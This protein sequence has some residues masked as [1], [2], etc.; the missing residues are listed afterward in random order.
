MNILVKC[1]NSSNNKTFFKL[2]SD[3]DREKA[4]V[5]NFIYTCMRKTGD[6]DEDNLLV[7]LIYPEHTELYLEYTLD[8]SR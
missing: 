8:Y 6:F 4:S 3:R 5:D 1:Q 2:I 7:E